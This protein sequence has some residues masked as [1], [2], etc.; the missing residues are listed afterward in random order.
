MCSLEIVINSSWT[1]EITPRYT[2]ENANHCTVILKLSVKISVGMVF[3]AGCYRYLQFFIWVP[4]AFCQVQNM[5]LPRFS[6]Q[7]NSL[8][9]FCLSILILP[10]FWIAIVTTM[11]FSC[12]SCFSRWS[13]GFGEEKEKMALDYCPFCFNSHSQYVLVKLNNLLFAKDN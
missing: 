13:H 3:P 10:G 9:R 2:V 6:C 1:S 8:S 5:K 11:L 4:W 7:E 12:W